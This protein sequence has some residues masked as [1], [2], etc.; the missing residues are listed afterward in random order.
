MPRE[1]VSGLTGSCEWL[2]IGAWQDMF[3]LHHLETR[4][5]T[6]QHSQQVLF[7]DGIVEMVV[8]E[9]SQVP[10]NDVLIVDSDILCR[11]NYLA[12]RVFNTKA[13]RGS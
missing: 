12:F 1:W 7:T 13:R 2:A 8:T 9:V 11:G 6:R 4:A 10:R 5:C 3:T